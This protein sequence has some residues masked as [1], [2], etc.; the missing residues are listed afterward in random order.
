MKIKKFPRTRE[1]ICTYMDIGCSNGLLQKNQTFAYNETIARNMKN[2][3]N[4]K[5][6]ILYECEISQ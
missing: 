5:L 1:N 2:I 3:G 6:S 4:M